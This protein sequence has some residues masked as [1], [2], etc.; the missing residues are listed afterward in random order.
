MGVGVD[1]HEAA[2]LE[3]RFMP[4][5]VKIEPPRIGIDL[6]RDPVL[7]ACRKHLFDVNVVAGAAQQLPPSHMPEDGGIRI[8]YCADDALG[9]RCAVHLETAVHARDDK[10]ERLQDLV[11]VVESAVRENVRFDAFEDLETP[12]IFPC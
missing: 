10:V 1:A 2:E 6:D 3:G 8:G 4:A 12:A 5:P 7:G 11:R 9:L